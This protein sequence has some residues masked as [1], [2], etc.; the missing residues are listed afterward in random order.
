MSCAL[1]AKRKPRRLCPAVAGEICTV[2]CAT[3][4]E[5]TLDCPVDCEYLLQAHEHEKLAEPAASDIPN[6]DISVDETFLR[7]HEWVFVALL[8]AIASVARQHPAVNDW[9]AREAM[10]GLIRTYRT[11]EAGLYYESKPEN[12]RAGEI[13]AAVNAC[14]ANIRSAE[15]NARGMAR[16]RDSTVLK[17]LVFLERLERVHSNGRARS[18]AFLASLSRFTPPEKISSD[19][20]E[21]A[22]ASL[23]L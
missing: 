11:L 21:P 4:R 13:F 2:C 22:A 14:V 18:R 17:I 7:E 23:I 20:V 5:Q 8:N 10:D 15:A 3:S 12:R 6:Q 16:L 1:C 19:S 9:D